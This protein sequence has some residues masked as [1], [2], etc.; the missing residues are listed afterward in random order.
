MDELRDAMSKRADSSSSL[1]LAFLVVLAL[2]SGAA[3]RAFHAGAPEA[4]V[5]QWE[6]EDYASDGQ[7]DTSFYEMRVETDGN[8]SIYDVAAG[9]P[10]ISGQ[11]G[12][13]NGHTVECQ[14]DMDDFDVPYCWNINSSKAVLE[15][16]LVDDVL[17]LGH[18]GV[19][20][21]F[22]RARDA[23][24]DDQLPEPLD[25]LISYD[26]P[27]GFELEMEYPFEG[28]EGNPVVEKSYLSDAIGCFS[29][30]ILSLDEHDCRGDA[31]QTVDFDECVN[32]LDGMKQI[33]IDG[34]TGYLGTIESDDLPDM[35]AITYV[36]HGAYAF[37]FRLSGYDE[38]VTKEQMQ[39]FEAIVRSVRFRY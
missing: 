18:N 36:Q 39:A 8:F 16:E 7:T 10:G 12:N 23:G 26:L 14:F 2:F 24:I 33:A 27:S 11:M 34:E 3:C 13:D 32:R 19:W 17:R 28:V 35:V 29:A 20:M 15:Y 25:D 1:L 5:G 30:R 31:R 9:N 6:C 22:H 4:F 37:E 38:Q 21:M